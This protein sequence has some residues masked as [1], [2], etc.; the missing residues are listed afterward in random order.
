MVAGQVADM[1]AEGA[2]P[3]LETVE[4]IHVHKTGAMIRC[5]VRAGAILGGATPTQLRRLT[6]YGEFLGYAF[7]VADDI[8][9]AEGTTATTGKMQGRDRERKKVTFPAV[10]GLPESKRRAGELMHSAL[11]ELAPFPASAEPL[12]EIARYVVARACPEMVPAMRRKN[13]LGRRLGRTSVR[14]KLKSK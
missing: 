9:D 7:Q 4:F 12:R 5:S 2:V 14:R 1:V 3:D 6:R 11:A 13:G 10:L 8:L